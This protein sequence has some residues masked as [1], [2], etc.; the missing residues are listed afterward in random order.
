MVSLTREPST[1]RRRVSDTGSRV[2]QQTG[3][4]SHPP[5]VLLRESVDGIVTGYSNVARVVAACY[6]YLVGIVYASGCRRLQ[7]VINVGIL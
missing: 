5:P 3:L 4:D 6:T 7:P 2:I 1:L